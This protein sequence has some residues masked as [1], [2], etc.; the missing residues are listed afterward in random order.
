[1]GVPGD[2]GGGFAVDLAGG[3]EEGGEDVVEV[4]VYEGGAEEVAVDLQA[5]LGGERQEGWCFPG[6]VL[7][8][9]DP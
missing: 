9:K 5:E 2:E 4:G 8:R 6:H 1:M 3:E 7:L